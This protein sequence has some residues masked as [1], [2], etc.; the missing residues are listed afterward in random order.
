[1]ENLVQDHPNK[2]ECILYKLKTDLEQGNYT[3]L[4]Y[5]L[6]HYLKYSIAFRFMGLFAFVQ[7]TEPFSSHEKPNAN[8][9]VV[10]NIKM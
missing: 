2:I 6:F 10:S 8:K 9:D 5:P 4:F 7:L 1:M 3:I